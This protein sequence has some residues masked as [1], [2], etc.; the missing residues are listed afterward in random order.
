VTCVVVVDG[1]VIVVVDGCIRDKVTVPSGS[2]N[3]GDGAAVMVCEV[4]LD[5]AV[6]P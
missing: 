4:V 6:S 2:Q 5:G 1:K 3:F